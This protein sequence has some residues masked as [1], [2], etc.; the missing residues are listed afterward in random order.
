[1]KDIRVLAINPGSTSTKIAVYQNTEPIFL[2]NIKHTTEELAPFSKITD[3]FQFR[4]EIILQQIHE[5]DIHIHGLQAVVG[6]G[7][8]LIEDISQ[9]RHGRRGRPQ[10]G[11]LSTR[12]WQSQAGET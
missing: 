6:R 12:A 3:Q 8:L 2:K 10:V 7:G 11:A 5:A 4:K 1:M 9:N